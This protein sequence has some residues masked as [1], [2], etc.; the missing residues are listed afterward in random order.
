M[1]RLCAFTDEAGKP[2]AEQIDAMHRNNLFLTE[3]RTV[4]GVNVSKLSPD[5]ARGIRSTLDSEG[6][7]VWSIGS[8]LGKVDISVDMD[9]YLDTVRHVCELANVLGTDKIRMFSFH[10]AYEDEPRVF[11]NLSRMVD[12]A[13]EY[14]VTLYHENEKNIY[15]DTAE[16]VLRIMDSVKGLRFVYDPANFLQ[17]GEP[18]D[19]TLPLFHHRCDYFHIKDVIA[20]TEELVPAGCGDGQIARLVD[21]IEGDTVLT[22]EPHLAIFDGYGAI[23]D[24][25]MKNKFVFSSNAEA[26][27]TAVKALKAI[28]CEC[29]YREANGAF[30]K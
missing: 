5:E 7:A 1:I 18:A 20:A 4:D 29:G 26:F 25:K 28:L 14:G 15:G 10:K 30:V 13:K 22:L 6:L 11:D 27:D 16:R 23:D 9:E 12:T 21:M 19:K 17:C 3:L 8:P 24:R 2:L